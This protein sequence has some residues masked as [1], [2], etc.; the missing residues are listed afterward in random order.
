MDFATHRPSATPAAVPMGPQLVVG[1][2]F[3][4]RAELSGRT[5]GD[6]SDRAIRT[7]DR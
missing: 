1:G 6:G 5:R 3:E 4:I 7:Y 2:E